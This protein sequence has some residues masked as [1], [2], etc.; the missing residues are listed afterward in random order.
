M[1]NKIRIIGLAAVMFAAVAVTSCKKDNKNEI[2]EINQADFYGTWKDGTDRIWTTVTFTANKVVY[3]NWL[4]GGYTLEDLTWTAFDNLAGK[5]ITDFPSGYKITGKVT[6]LKDLRIPTMDDIRV[7]AVVGD[8][9]YN[10][11][12]IS[13]DKKSIIE[14][15]LRTVA[16]EGI[17]GEYPFEKQP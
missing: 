13:G 8:M 1:T 10:W 12:Y 2:N 5:H 15:E 7:E 17:F 4:G 9:V 14:G 6:Q 11:W 3:L 16:H